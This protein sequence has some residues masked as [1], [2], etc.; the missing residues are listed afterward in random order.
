MA[1]INLPSE[2]IDA[3]A[4][5]LAATDDLSMQAQGAM[6][7]FD[8]S[9]GDWRYYLVTSLVDTVGRRKTYK[10]LI[11]IFDKIN[12]PR[13]MTV[14]D[15]HLGSPVDPFF[16]LVSGAVGI[17]GGGYAIFSD[18]VF[19]GVAFDGLIYRSVREPPAPQEAER[20]EKRFA[21]RV[22]DLIRTT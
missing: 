4:V 10:L 1:A 22:K 13:S 6:W 16:K 7:V 18:C 14:N 3:G 20:I 15:V 17:S 11:E 8:H 9:L 2:L 12:V 19:N 5:I 21:R